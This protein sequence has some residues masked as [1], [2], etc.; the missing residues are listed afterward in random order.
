MSPLRHVY[1]SESACNMFK[2]AWR[3][4][5][6]FLFI[7]LQISVSFTGRFRGGNCCIEKI[8]LVEHL[9]CRVSDHQPHDCLLNRLFRRRLKK[10]SNLRVTGLCE[11]HSLVTGEF[12]AQR[13][14]NAE[15]V[16]MWLWFL[17]ARVPAVDNFSCYRGICLYFMMTSWNGNIFGVTDHLCGEFTGHRWIP[18]TKAS[19]WELW[20]FLWSP[21]E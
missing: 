16:S 7:L 11:G 18:R 8:L 15:N 4:W 2:L 12:S 21:P 5:V 19:D 1:T 10:T 20:C 14:S 17:S 3:N 9:K 13:T 6:Q